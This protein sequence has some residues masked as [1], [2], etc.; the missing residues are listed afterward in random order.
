MSST[1]RAHLPKVFIF[2]VLGLLGGAGVAQA[3][4]TP[5]G[6]RP[7][8]ACEQGEFCTW[9]GEF[10]SETMQRLDLRMVS[11]GD[12]LALPDNTE[13][14]SF[15]NRLDRE[16]T[17]YQDGDCGAEGDFVTYPGHDTF[18]PRSPFAVRSIEIW[19]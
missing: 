9:K 15:A 4:P 3:D 12:C 19:E 5:P 8:F 11:P 6:G 13:G 17:V 1:L 7:E 2:A 14:R 10:Y 16:V 18:A